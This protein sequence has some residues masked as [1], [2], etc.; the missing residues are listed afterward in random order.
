MT[1]KFIVSVPG[2]SQPVC[3]EAD[4]YSRPSGILSFVKGGE[5][6]A[7]FPEYDLLA[8][9][10]CLH[11]FLDLKQFQVPEPAM[12][13]ATFI[14]SDPPLPAGGRQELKSMLSGVLAMGWLAWAAAITVAVYH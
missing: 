12:C 6:V 1:H 13:A 9:S 5:V 14:E 7:E 3:I 11:A 8:R 2:R 10:S 4:S